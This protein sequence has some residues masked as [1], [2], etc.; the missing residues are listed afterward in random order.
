MDI[1]LWLVLLLLA[2]LYTALS[3]FRPPARG[4]RA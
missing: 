2:M 3:I 1:S 4:S